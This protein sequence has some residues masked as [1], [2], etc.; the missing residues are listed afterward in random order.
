MKPVTQ[1]ASPQEADRKSMER[2][3]QLQ[4]A[5]EKTFAAP[6]TTKDRGQELEEVLE[7]AEMF[8]ARHSQAL[9]APVFGR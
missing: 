6:K 8:P 7:L 1:E 4:R 9:D 2:S 5:A 3:A